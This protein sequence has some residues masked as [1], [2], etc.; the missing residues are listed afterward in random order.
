MALPKLNDSPKYD[1]VIPSTNE[2]VRYRPYL[3]KEEKVLMMAMESQD[4]KAILNAV[5]DTIEACVDS[6]IDK[7]KL[8]IFDVEYMFTQI[9]AKSVGE[10]SKINMKCSECKVN[11]EISVDV[12]AIGIVVPDVNKTIQVTPAIA[13]EMKWP[14]FSDM[15]KL[16]SL[17][18][19]SMTTNA[20]KLIGKSIEAIVTEEERILTKDV[21]EKELEEFIDSMTK[22]QFAKVSAFIEA[23][24]KLSHDVNFNCT[25]CD[26]ENKHTLQGMTDF[27]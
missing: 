18:S 27:F 24:P 23:M 8:A 12:G 15:V 3:V 1:I 22:D 25:S 6:N 20:F 2:K 11:N 9:R 13:I 14:S 19:K 10:T 21:S 5:V 16:E 17:D 4:T 7:N 26:H